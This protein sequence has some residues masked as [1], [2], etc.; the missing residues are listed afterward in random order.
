MTYILPPG[1][2]EEYRRVFFTTILFRY[3]VHTP[4]EKFGLCGFNLMGGKY[5]ERDLSVKWIYEWEAWNEGSI[6]RAGKVV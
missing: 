3:D 5:G 2:E 4:G 6:M 1:E